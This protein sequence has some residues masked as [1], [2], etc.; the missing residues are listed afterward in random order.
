MRSADSQNKKLACLEGP[1]A[2]DEA[3]RA[4]LPPVSFEAAGIRYIPR[5]GQIVARFNAGWKQKPQTAPTRTH[6]TRKCT[7]ESVRMR[8]RVFPTST[9]EHDVNPLNMWVDPPRHAR[10]SKKSHVGRGRGDRRGEGHCRR[11]GQNHAGSLTMGSYHP[12]KHASER[13]SSMACIARKRI[14]LPVLPPSLDQQ[15][16][17]NPELSKTAKIHVPENGRNSSTRSSLAHGHTFGIHALVENRTKPPPAQS[18]RDAPSL[19]T[20][21]QRR[22]HQQQRR[23]PPACCSPPRQGDR[24]RPSTSPRRRSPPCDRP[25]SREKK[26]RQE[27]SG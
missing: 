18:G 11:N 15:P 10:T 2:A 6:A 27:T 8:S 7:K 13:P 25:P 14:P 21:A 26:K 24:L 17:T 1:D 12:P 5:Q 16:L 20:S 22:P 19:L 9:H 3:A 23:L 4:D